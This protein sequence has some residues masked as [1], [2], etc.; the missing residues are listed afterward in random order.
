MN[1][2][3][4]KFSSDKIVLYGLIGSS[5]FIIFNIILFLSFYRSLPPY[6][7][8]FNQMP[9][10]I[11]RLGIREQFFIPLFSTILMATGNYWIVYHYYEQLPLVARILCV[12]TLLLSFLLTVFTIKM[13]SLIV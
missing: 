6:I 8:L 4:K 9:W 3:I 11:A 10:G 7:P 2:N 1:V 12:T 5:A 13:L